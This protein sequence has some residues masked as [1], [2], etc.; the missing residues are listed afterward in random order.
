MSTVDTLIITPAGVEVLVTNLELEHSDVFTFWPGIL[1]REL[2]D[3]LQVCAETF[4]GEHTTKLIKIGSKKD[5][6]AIAI[7][8]GSQHES[9]AL[10][11]IHHG[12]LHHPPVHVRE[13]SM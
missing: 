9:I 13:P 4:P 3:F 12:Y 5:N 11:Y 7:F 2:V 10:H 1:E 6:I 8:S